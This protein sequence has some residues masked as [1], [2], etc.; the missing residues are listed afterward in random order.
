MDRR[1][2]LVVILSPE[3][4][5]NVDHVSFEDATKFHRLEYVSQATWSSKQ[6]GAMV[7]GPS[8][9]EFLLETPDRTVAALIGG[10][11]CGRCVARY[12]RTYVRFLRYV[13]TY[14]TQWSP[15]RHVRTYVRT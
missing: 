2:D 14:V 13:R 12:V 3:D 11:V 5:K 1:V 10:I 9:L 8:T 4:F 15:A 6:T 7:I